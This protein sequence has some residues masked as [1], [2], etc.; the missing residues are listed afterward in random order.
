MDK[1][2]SLIPDNKSESTNT[3]NETPSENGKQLFRSFQSLKE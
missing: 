3:N 1:I 2:N